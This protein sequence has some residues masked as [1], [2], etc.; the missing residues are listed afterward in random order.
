MS[1]VSMILPQDVAGDA[2]LLIAWLV[3]LVRQK[4]ERGKVKNCGS[5]VEEEEGWRL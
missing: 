1:V 4:T 3:L 2:R 5:G